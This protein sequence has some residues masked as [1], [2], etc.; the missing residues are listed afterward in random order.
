MCGLLE[1]LILF[2][3]LVDI[4]LTGHVIHGA[5]MQS[6]DFKKFLGQFPGWSYP[7]GWTAAYKAY[8]F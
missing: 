8:K 3:D 6:S 2:Q 1:E 7:V 5:E 4:S